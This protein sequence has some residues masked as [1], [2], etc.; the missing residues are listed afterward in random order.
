MLPT[1][2]T[3]PNGKAFTPWVTLPEIYT[4]D[5]LPFSNVKAFTPWVT[6]PEIYTLDILHLSKWKNVHVLPYHAY[7]LR[8]YFTFSNGKAFTSWETLP[9]IYTSTYFFSNGKA[10]TLGRSYNEYILSKPSRF[11]EYIL[12]RTS[13][14]QMEK[15]SRLGRPFQEFMLPMYF[16]FSNEKAFTPWVTL[17]GT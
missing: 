15:P 1:Y 4:L 11:G 17:P 12:R 5:I 16:T 13:P 10:F 2:F 14:F 9:G 3:F 8:T 6:L 7:I